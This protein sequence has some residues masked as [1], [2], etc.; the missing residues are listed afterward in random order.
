[1]IFYFSGTGNTRWAAM[2]MARLLNDTTVEIAA[3]MRHPE[4]TELTTKEPLGICFP[5]YGWDAPTIVYDFIATLQRELDQYPTYLYYICT[6]G[7][8][9]GITGD[10]L[11]RYVRQLGWQFNAGFSLRMPNTYTCLPGF[12]VDSDD[13]RSQK[14]KTAPKTLKDIA[15]TITKRSEG[16]FQLREGSMAWIKTVILGGYF[17]RFLMTDK[18]FHT[19]YRCTGCGKCEIAC[20]VKNIEMR[21]GIPT[22]KGKCTMCLSCYH[23]CPHHALNWGKD[24]EKKGQYLHKQYE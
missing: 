15:T 13:V 5:I 6:M 12:D 23:N 14:L 16:I 19:N 7:D 10:R 20:P 4:L 8:D 22:W 18:K 24:T 17:R 3:Y 2:E 1:M 11:Q 9:I 21:Q